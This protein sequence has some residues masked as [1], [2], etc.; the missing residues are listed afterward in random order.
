MSLTVLEAIYRLTLDNAEIDQTHIQILDIW[1]E[2]VT[3]HLSD[4]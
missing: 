4:G 2:E 1:G 3:E